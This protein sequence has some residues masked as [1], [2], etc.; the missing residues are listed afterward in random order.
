MSNSI[1]H[2]GEV[3]PQPSGVNDFQHAARRTGVGDMPLQSQSGEPVKNSVGTRANRAWTAPVEAAKGQGS[4]AGSKTER[5]EILGD[6]ASR[7]ATRDQSQARRGNAGLWTAVVLLTLALI[8]VSAYSYTALKRQ[9]IT[10]AQLPGMRGIENSLGQRLNAT[11]ATLLNLTDSSQGLS[12]QLNQLDHR[13][14]SMLGRTRE[15]TEELVAQ[16]ENRMEARMNERDQAV[17]ARLALVESGQKEDRDRVAQLQAEVGGVKKQVAADDQD[18]WRQ[19]SQLNQRSND[20]LNRM[21]E[22]DRSIHQPREKVTFEASRQAVSEIVPGISFTVTATNSAYQ[23]FNG[24]LTLADAG[25]NVWLRDVAAEQSVTF[26]A[27]HDPQPFDLVVTSINPAGVAGFLVMPAGGIPTSNEGK[28]SAASE[29]T[30]S[31]SS[32]Q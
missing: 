27:G 30:A 5:N 21:N 23:R 2:L 6:G 8:G 9:G 22:L 13:L 7:H 25:R 11:E 16:A 19:L 15:Q 10:V 4:G 3:S 12:A 1:L 18:A 24:Y 31:E 29:G 28:A 14:G 20:N 32:G 17:E 26:Y